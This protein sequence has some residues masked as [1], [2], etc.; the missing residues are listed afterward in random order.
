MNMAAQRMDGAVLAPY[1]SV[2]SGNDFKGSLA[3]KALNVSG[4]CFRI[5]FNAPEILTMG[6]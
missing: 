1:A 2:T 3:C 5:P 6:R 4:T